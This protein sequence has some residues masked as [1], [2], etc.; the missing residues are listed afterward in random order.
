MALRGYADNA[1]STRNDR[2]T[3]YDVIARVT[4]DLRDK[5]MTA[6]TDFPGYAEA[7]HRNQQLWTAL[8]VDLSDDA[9]PLPDDLKARLAYLADFTRH[10]TGKILRDNASVM[11]LLEI[12]MAVM[13]GLKT[14]GPS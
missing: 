12:N 10:H 3:E 4:K 2:R 1:A 5:A 11:P 9:N 13:R 14:E 8:M 7:L 6:K